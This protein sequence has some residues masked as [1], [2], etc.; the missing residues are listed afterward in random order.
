MKKVWTQQFWTAQN[1]IALTLDMN[2][3]DKFD[4]TIDYKEV[5]KMY[6]LAS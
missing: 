1:F 6:T 2:W 4:K 3:N 5:E